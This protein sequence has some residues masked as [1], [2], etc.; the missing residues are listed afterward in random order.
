MIKSLT[1]YGGTVGQRKFT[2]ELR[3]LNSKQLDL[4][5]RM[6]SVYKEKELE[7]RT[8]LAG[9]IKRGKCDLTIYYEAGMEEKKVGLNRSLMESYHADLSEVAE[10]IGQENVDYMSLLMRIPDVFRSEKEE[11]NEEEWNTIFDLIKQALKMFN[12]YRSQEGE[13]LEGDFAQRVNHILTLESELEGPAEQRV[14]KVKERIRQ[15]LQ[16]FIEKEKIDH[17]RFEQEVIYYLEKMDVTEERVRLVANCKYFLEILE[18][19]DAQGKKLG[20]ISQEIGRE[21]NTLGSKAND[22]DIQRI[23]VQ[24]KDE[25]EKVKEQVLNVL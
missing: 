2:I 12:D 10:N 16:D 13:G 9:E 7:L 19:G 15:N 14:I 25:L 23:V 22:S 3:S 6:P 17:N 11:F 5:V 21:I 24:M 8:F 1:G 18:K 4:N 20:F